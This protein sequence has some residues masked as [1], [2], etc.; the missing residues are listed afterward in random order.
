M[1]TRTIFSRCWNEQTCRNFGIW[2]SKTAVF[3]DELPAR[4][5]ASALAPQLE[6]I[7]L[8]MGCLTA[9]GVAAL[10]SNAARFT[11]LKTLD[12]SE[13]HLREEDRPVLHAT[14]AHVLSAEQRQLDDPDDIY[15]AVG[16]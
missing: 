13:N 8:S 11:N 12:V 15:P 7:D 16:E 4:L 14:F 5:A 10:V 9:E 2:A 1:R 6:S 3:A